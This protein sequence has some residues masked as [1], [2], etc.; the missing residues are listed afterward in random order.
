MTIQQRLALATKFG[1][2]S[3]WDAMANAGANDPECWLLAGWL[4]PDAQSDERLLASVI[5][6]THGPVAEEALAVRIV[7]GTAD[8]GLRRQRLLA[9]AEAAYARLAW[10][11]PRARTTPYD[12]AAP[13]GQIQAA[14]VERL[15][16]AGR[17]DHACEVA[18]RCAVPATRLGR[19]REALGERIFDRAVP[20]DARLRLVKRAEI[21]FP[22]LVGARRREQGLACD[23]LP[24]VSAW[25]TLTSQARTL[26]SLTVAPEA[27][28][29]A[30]AAAEVPAVIT[31]LEVTRELASLAPEEAMGFAAEVRAL[32][33]DG[34]TEP[35]PIQGR[36]CARAR[37]V[38]ALLF[39]ALGGAGALEA[40][41]KVIDAMLS[42]GLGASLGPHFRAL[43]ANNLPVERVG[44]LLVRRVADRTRPPK[45]RIQAREALSVLAEAAAAARRNQPLPSPEGQAAARQADDLLIAA[46]DDPAEPEEFK[47][48]IGS[49]LTR[50]MPDRI[51]A[52]QGSVIDRVPVPS[53]ATLQ[54]GQSIAGFDRNEIIALLRDP[55]ADLG[56]VLAAIALAGPLARMAPELAVELESLLRALVADGRRFTDRARNL[57][58][59]VEA[60]SAH[61]AIW[62]Q[63]KPGERPAGPDLLS[64]LRKIAA[65]QEAPGRGENS[66][67][68]ALAETIIGYLAPADRTMIATGLESD[69][70][71][72]R[73]RAWARLHAYHALVVL[74]GHGTGADE[75]LFAALADPGED[76]VLRAEAHALL[77]PF[78]AQPVHDLQAKGLLPR[79]PIPPVETLFH[80]LPRFERD[81]EGEWVLNPD[82]VRLGNL[83]YPDDLIAALR[84]PTRSGPRLRR[85]GLGDAG[86]TEAARLCRAAGRSPAWRPG[87]RRGDSGG[88]GGPPSRFSPRR[89]LRRWPARARPLAR[90]QLMY[91][92]LK[93]TPQDQEPS[94]LLISFQRV[95]IE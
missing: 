69:I 82:A 17:I 81:T 68:A 45:E 90:R 76:P 41:T 4:A 7:L 50:W 1:A 58:V 93:W 24:A 87:Q 56:R 83:V 10:L 22:G 67:A 51:P 13:L 49:M 31:A 6:N 92:E 36:L 44:L 29:S 37:D 14:A 34:R 71:D 20:D 85:G 53:I 84:D 89:A 33:R 54:P 5:D 15:A 80:N 72:R 40:L 19:L 64:A 30:L 75:T 66:R 78:M 61:R 32:C 35:R 38:H 27:V 70:A 88:G 26:A 77:A 57:T 3:L 94:C 86:R 91:L 73:F 12:H 16:A 2:T 46:L 42:A 74:S 11:S 65:A 18:V 47:S 79:P 52:L 62:Q 28:R 25:P 63:L 48:A 55:N 59:T 39:A 9:V 95:V 60:W 21:M 8:P 43:G 23:P